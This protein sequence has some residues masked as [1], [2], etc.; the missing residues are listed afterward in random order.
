MDLEYPDL[1]LKEQSNEA[2]CINVT[3][4]EIFCSSC[5][6]FLALELG[7]SVMLMDCPAFHKKC[8]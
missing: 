6:F 3:G 7:K 5:N 8:K 4:S 1:N 2:A